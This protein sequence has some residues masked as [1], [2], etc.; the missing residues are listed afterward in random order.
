MKVIKVLGMSLLLLVLIGSALAVIY[1]KY[2]A[3][4]LFIDI[5][6]QEKLLD[7]YEIEW[8]QMQLEQTT[9]LEHNRI[10]RT[11]KKHR[12]VQPLPP[13]IIFIKP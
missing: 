9:Y 10:E 4:L 8:A 7:D 5:A 13:S 6:K 1:G 12:L 11:A 3:R 2:Y